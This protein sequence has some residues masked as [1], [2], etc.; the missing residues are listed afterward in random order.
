MWELSGFGIET[1][2]GYR[3]LVQ[4]TEHEVCE[5]ISEYYNPMYVKGKV[6][7]N[8]CEDIVGGRVGEYHCLGIVSNIYFITLCKDN[9]IVTVNY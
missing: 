2:L 8:P 5:Q 3:C 1:T 6:P 9:F 7:E 4:R